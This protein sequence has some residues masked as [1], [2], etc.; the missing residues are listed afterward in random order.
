MSPS[1]VVDQDMPDPRI[2]EDQSDHCGLIGHA[3]HSHV[4]RQ[5]RPG[6]AE[7]PSR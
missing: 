3:M 5:A 7:A 1:H 6:K 4:R 2:E